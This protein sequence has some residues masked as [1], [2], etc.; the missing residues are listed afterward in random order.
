MNLKIAV[1]VKRLRDPQIEVRQTA[2][3]A[4]EDIGDSD[5]LVPLAIVYATDPD[6]DV[7]RLA[8]KAGKAIYQNL[9]RRADETRPATDD[10]RERAAEILRKAQTKRGRRS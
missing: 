9:Q 10:E 3:R 8:Q 4:L 1:W 5:A 2:I 6:P 7:R